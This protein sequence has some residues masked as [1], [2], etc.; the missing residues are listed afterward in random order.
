MTK[1]RH[2]KIKSENTFYNFHYMTFCATGY[3]LAQFHKVED[4]EQ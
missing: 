3:V 1:K 4:I 2:Y